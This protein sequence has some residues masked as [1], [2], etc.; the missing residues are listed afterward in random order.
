MN[1]LLALPTKKFLFGIA[2]NFAAYYEPLLGL[3]QMKIW[4]EITASDGLENYIPL[5]LLSLTVRISVK[6]KF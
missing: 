6:L 4:W 5:N 1:L 2:R 3:A